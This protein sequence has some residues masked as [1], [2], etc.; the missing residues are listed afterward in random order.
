MPPAR[1]QEARAEIFIDFAMVVRGLKNGSV[2]PRKGRWRP[3]PRFY[4]AGPGK[5]TAVQTCAGG[6]APAA[7][8]LASDKNLWKIHRREW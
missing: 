8:L 3:T 2:C 4:A 6:G 1:P 5:V 7:K